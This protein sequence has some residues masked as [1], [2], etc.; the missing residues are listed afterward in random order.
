MVTQLTTLYQYHSRSFS[1]PLG[2]GNRMNEK[3]CKKEGE[4]SE[5]QTGWITAAHP[6]E[7]WI[8]Q[9]QVTLEELSLPLSEISMLS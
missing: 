8:Y 9:F 1:G 5:N 2:Q 7:I 4:V 3:R 6:N